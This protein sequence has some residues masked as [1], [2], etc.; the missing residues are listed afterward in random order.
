[1][2]Q[3]RYVALDAEETLAQFM[4]NGWP[5]ERQFVELMGGVISRARD[6]AQSEHGRTALFGEMVALLW[7]A[8]NSDGA[9]RLEQLWNQI[10]QSHSFSLVCGYPLTN[11]YREEHSGLFQQICSEHSAVVPDEHYSKASEEQRLRSVARWQQK[12]LALAAEVERRKQTEMDSRK[13]AAI[14]ESSDDAIASKDLNGI[15]SSWNAA[16]ERM[17]GYKAE[18]IIG[19]SIKTIIPPELHK[20]EDSI[21]ARIRKGE[22]V[23]HFETVRLT[24]SGERLNISLT[25]S[26]L[27]DDQG[28]VIGAAKIARDITQRKRAEEALRRAEKLAITGR[29]A[30][31]IAHEINNPLEAVT[32]AL[33]LLRDHVQ[34]NAGSRY[35]NLAEAELERV[36]DI[37]KQT[38]AFYRQRTAPESVNVAELIDNLVPIFAKKIAQKRIMLV[39]RE[40]PATVWGIRSELRQLFSNILDN[41]I[42]AIP[43][44][45]KIEIEVDG[46]DGSAVV[47]INDSGPGLKQ[48]H[49]TRLFE[50]FFAPNEP[51]G[52]GLG[53][54]VAQ[55]IAEKHGGKITAESNTEGPNRGTTIRVRLAGVHEPEQRIA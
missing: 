9:L 14:V 37:T 19:R 16:A 32:N 42:A 10:A 55:E 40:Q 6:S 20:E 52:A 34:G 1:V 27:K 5:D 30:L 47:S 3:G 48:E 38:L 41:A 51:Q 21:L 18:E 8:G 31:M 44:N 7:D 23:E 39:R 36:V 15:V 12:A 2:E 54:W 46:E 43:S 26:P 24:K 25:I 33:Y 13:L 53:L 50:P 49:L 22:R 28:R 29:M 4:V 17:F 11:F 35:L 45:G